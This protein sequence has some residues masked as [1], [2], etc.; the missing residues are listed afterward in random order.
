M[1]AIIVYAANRTTAV[2]LRRTAG[3]G[4]R[5]RDNRTLPRR[6]LPIGESSNAAANSARYTRSPFHP[7]ETERA[8]SLFGPAATAPTTGTPLQS[9]AQATVDAGQRMGQ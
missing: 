9:A 6:T 2:P 3:G 4:H 5:R 7:G 8:R 1:V